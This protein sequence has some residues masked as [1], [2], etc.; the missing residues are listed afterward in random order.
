M[1][2]NLFY[3]LCIT[4]HV[5]TAFLLSRHHTCS[6]Y[7]F[8]VSVSVTAHPA[9]LSGGKETT[10]VAASKLGPAQLENHHTD[11]SCLAGPVCPF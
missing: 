1:S 2:R 4:F 5:Y 10:L 6:S 8:P 7:T 11:L 9:W 3:V